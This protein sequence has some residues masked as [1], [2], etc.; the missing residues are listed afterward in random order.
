MEVKNSNMYSLRIN[1]L[2]DRT[3]QFVLDWCS[4]GI[5]GGNYEFDKVFLK[6]LKEKLDRNEE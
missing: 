2:N 3:L 4:I 5:K 1:E 6:L